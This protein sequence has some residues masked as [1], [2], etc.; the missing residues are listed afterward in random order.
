MKKTIIFIIVILIIVFGFI[1]LSDW[2]KA[3]EEGTEGENKEQP[4]EQNGQ[5]ESVD[6]KE[7]GQEGTDV[8]ESVSIRNFAFSPSKITIKKGSQ[9]VWTNKDSVGHTVTSD[10]GN[11]LDS[12]LLMQND[13]YSHTFNEVGLFKYHCTPHPFMKGEVIVE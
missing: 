8:A 1:L 6:G 2:E 12:E 9:V 10:E 13:N 11:E 7:A 3:E 4:T 5:T